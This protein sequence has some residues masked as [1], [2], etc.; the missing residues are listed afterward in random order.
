MRLTGRGPGWE[1]ADQV[2]IKI[3]C[4]RHLLKSWFS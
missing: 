2:H 1:S 3:T 4:S